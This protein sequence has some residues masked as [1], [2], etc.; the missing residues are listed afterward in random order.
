VRVVR[1]LA[2]SDGFEEDKARIL[3]FH[4]VFPQ[5][6]QQVRLPQELSSWR[7][8]SRLL[9]NPYWFHGESMN[10]FARMRPFFVSAIGLLYS[11]RVLERESY[12]TGF[13]KLAPVS[14]SAT[15]LVQAARTWNSANADLANFIVQGLGALPLLGRD[16]LKDRTRLMEFK[17]DAV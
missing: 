10:V 3:D 2:L 15:S 6:I 12:N 16:G 5:A 17:Y 13:L 9:E 11:S 4:L 7:R 8:R 14:P 1:L